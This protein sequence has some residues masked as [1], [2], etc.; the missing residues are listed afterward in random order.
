[1]TTLLIVLALLLALYVFLAF[2]RLP[3]RNIDRLKGYDY[4]H[5]GLWN[6]TLPE[7]S[8][9]AFRHA[10]DNGFGIELDVHVTSDDRL[11]VFHD[12]TLDRMC[13]VPG[14]VADKTMAELLA[15][16]LKDSGHRMPTF[17]EVLEI[18]GGKVPL[19][20]EIKSDKRNA[21]LSRLVWERLQR[22]EG[23]YCI[24]SFDPRV[25]SWFRKNAPQV[26]RGQLAFGFRGK[27]RT[28]VNILLSTLMQNVAGRPD[29]IAFEAKTD[30]TPAMWLQRLLRPWLVC[31]TIHSQQDM[32]AQRK[33]YDLQIFDGFV[34]C[35]K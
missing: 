32:D 17:D 23:P 7:N 13:G 12:D 10:V 35:K 15:L 31:W 1:M 20:I 8:A 3:R 6:D 22:Y 4:A 29:F 34:P 21:L 30:N 9:A 19:I 26:I 27:K 2:P 28:P 16:R 18:V 5:R 14:K 25:V 33:R 11:I 24:E